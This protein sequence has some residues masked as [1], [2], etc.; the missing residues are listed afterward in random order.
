MN[1]IAAA[2]GFSGAV[3]IHL[4]HG[5]TRA[6]DAEAKPTPRRLVSTGRFDADQYLQRHYMTHDPLVAL[7]ANSL[8]PF[9][10]T[11]E[12]L[13]DANPDRV[14]VLKAMQNWG[15]H[16]GLAAPVQDYAYGPAFL[17]LFGALD[18]EPA[19]PLRAGADHGRLM[20]RATQLHVAAA[21]ALP[22]E[23]GLGADSNLNAREMEVLRFAAMGRTEQDTALSLSLSRRGV[24]FHLARAVEKLGAENKTAAVARAVSAGL[25]RI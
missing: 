14:R 25:I 4:G 19:C 16:T 23:N 18:G 10:W 1:D 20:L 2:Y 15:M 17:N 6:G 3:Y 11:L 22:S 24:Q 7:A 8:A 21:R 9:I 12:G 13:A 5:L